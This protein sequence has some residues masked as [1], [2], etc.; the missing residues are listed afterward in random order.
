MVVVDK[1]G[2]FFGLFNIVDVALALALVLVGGAVYLKLSA[3]QRGALDAYQSR[4]DVWID[5]VVWVPPERAWL[6]ESLT[7]GLERHDDRSGRVSAIVKE[8]ETTEAGGLE[9]RVRLQAAREKNARYFWGGKPV[10]P[11]ERIRIRLDDALLEGWLRGA[12]TA[13]VAEP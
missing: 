8:V 7:P 11:G 13:D 9:V 1:K 3:P 10:L 2:R 6:A 12:P 5:V 4:A